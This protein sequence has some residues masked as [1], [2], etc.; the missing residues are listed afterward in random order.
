MSDINYEAINENFP[1]NGVDNSTQGFRD[2]FQQIKDNFQYAK[3]EIENLVDSSVNTSSNTNFNNNSLINL[4]LLQATQQSSTTALN[5]V[6]NNYNVSYLFGHLHA[7]R[8]ENSITLTFTDWPTSGPANYAK[9]RLVIFTDGTNRQITFA[10]ENGNIKTK[11][12]FPNPFQHNSTSSPKVIDV[13]TYD[14]GINVYLE[15]VGE[16]S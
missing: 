1:A 16:F 11:S 14:K 7:L 3:A 13:W 15:Y 12:D 2:N 10:T 4:N 5:G 9:M 8:I 6:V